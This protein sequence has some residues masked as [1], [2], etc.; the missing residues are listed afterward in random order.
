MKNVVALLIILTCTLTDMANA[1][2]K[3]PEAKLS[4]IEKIQ[5]AAFDDTTRALTHL[6]VEKKRIR[7]IRNQKTMYIVLGGSTAVM[8]GGGLLLASDLNSSSTASYDPTN[9]AGLGLMLAGTTGVLISS[10]SLGISYLSLNPYTL[11]KYY[12]LID[13][14]KANKPLPIFYLK[15]MAPY[16][17]V[18]NNSQ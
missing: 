10:A 6:F 7:H 13:M 16:L 9:Y 14:H 12:R 11:K 1:Q 5:M 15:R 2:V 8:V 4:K 18:N 17:L 3:K